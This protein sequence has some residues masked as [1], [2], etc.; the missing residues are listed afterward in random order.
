MEIL[1]QYWLEYKWM[2]HFTNNSLDMGMLIS[3]AMPFLDIYLRK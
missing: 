1:T 2:Q 3:P